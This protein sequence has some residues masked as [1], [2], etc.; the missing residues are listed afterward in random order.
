M[1]SNQVQFARC[2]ATANCKHCGKP[3][4]VDSLVVAVGEPYSML[5]HE[6]CAPYYDYNKVFPHDK[7]LQFFRKF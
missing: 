5:L 4:E 7:P 6:G 2:L 1:S 3:I